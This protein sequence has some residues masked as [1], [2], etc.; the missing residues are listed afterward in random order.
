MPVSDI[1]QAKGAEV[2]TINQTEGLAAA[3]KSLREHRFGA[4]VVSDQAGKMVGII[5]ERDIVRA[6]GELGVN[7]LV[8]KVQDV[9]TRAVR[10]AKP[11]DTI[12][13][14]MQLMAKYHIRHVPI[15]DDGQLVGLI[16]QTDI[17][18]EQLTR[19]DSQVQVMKNLN[20]AR[21]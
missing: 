4:L 21:T 5:S 20:I 13:Q 6:V 7:G 3:A 10:T 18:Q 17:I 16:S 9:M 14:V 11:S 2:V 15:I 19:Q 1:L 8:L 12:E